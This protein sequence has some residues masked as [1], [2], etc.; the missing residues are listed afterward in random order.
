MTAFWI[1]MYCGLV[2]FNGFCAWLAFLGFRPFRHRWQL[3]IW[4]A[5]LVIENAVAALYINA[6][7]AAPALLL[8]LR[9]AWLGGL[10]VGMWIMAGWVLQGFRENHNGGGK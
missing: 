9:L 4:H 7:S 8:L 2:V 5:F 10:L 6:N 1:A 3:V